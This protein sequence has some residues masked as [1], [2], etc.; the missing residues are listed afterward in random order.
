M[1]ATMRALT[2]QKASR[3]LWMGEVIVP[4]YGHNDVLIKVMQTAICGTDV[5]IY[6]WD[7][8]AQKTI[9]IGMTIFHKDLIISI[10]PV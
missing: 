5:H 8:W 3:G 2:K 6:N 7:Q 4:Q 10:G 9:P 1:T